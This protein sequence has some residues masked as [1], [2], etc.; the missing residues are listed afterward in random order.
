MSYYYYFT[1]M[2]VTKVRLDFGSSRGT[3]VLKADMDGALVTPQSGV[4][5]YLALRLFPLLPH[6]CFWRT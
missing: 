5:Q 1:T 6:D 4:D 3:T 2:G